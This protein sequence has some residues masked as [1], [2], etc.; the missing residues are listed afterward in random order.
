[1]KITLQQLRAIND[2]S[3]AVSTICEMFKAAVGD[4]TAEIEFNEAAQGLLLG[5]PF[6]RQWWA[7]LVYH[8]IIPAW[9]MRRRNLSGADLSKANLTEVNL[10]GANLSGADLYRATLCRAKLSCADL[11]GANLRGANLRG[12]SLGGAN[13][14][15]ADLLDADLRGADLH[16]ANVDGA[17]WDNST[18]WP[19]A[20]EL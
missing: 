9:S 13:L 6:W 4:E 10:R 19:D 15:R 2:S 17:N 8:G 18:Q 20:F 14:G 7:F 11:R 3:R 1:M 16:A 12:A 5:D